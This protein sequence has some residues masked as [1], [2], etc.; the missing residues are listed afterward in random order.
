VTSCSSCN[1]YVWIEHPNGEWTKYTHFITNSGDRGGIR[2]FPNP[3]SGV[4]KINY[5]GKLSMPLRIEILDLMGRS[6]QVSFELE[7]GGGPLDLSHLPNGVYGLRCWTKE[8]FRTT[9]VVKQ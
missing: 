7:E 5:E 2:V 6:R 9:L 8:D 3:T 1:N 4:V